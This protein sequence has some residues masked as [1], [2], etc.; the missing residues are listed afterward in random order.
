M[1]TRLDLTHDFRSGQMKQDAGALSMGAPFSFC[2][3]EKIFTHWSPKR[4]QDAGGVRFL[5]AKIEIP[6]EG[7]CRLGRHVCQRCARCTYRSTGP[8]LTVT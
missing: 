5:G 7:V 2:S 1:E 4:R 6:I 3:S 8:Y